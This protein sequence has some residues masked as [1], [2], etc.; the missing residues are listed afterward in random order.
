MYD[1][2]GHIVQIIDS[3]QVGG[4]QKLLVTMAEVLQSHRFRLTIITLDGRPSPIQDRLEALSVPVVHISGH[5]ALF[6]P[7]RLWRIFHFLRRERFDVIHT[8]LTHANILGTV[9]GRLA[10]TPVVASLHNTRLDRRQHSA[11]KE[12]L[13]IAALRYGAC[14]VIAV[15]YVVKEAYRHRLRGKAIDVVA[16]AVSPVS[17]LA[18]IDRAAIRSQLVGDPERPLIIAVGRLTVQKGYPDLLAALDRLRL[19]YPAV[20]LIIAGEGRLKSKLQQQITAM[21]LTDHVLL[22]GQRDD[23]PRLLAAS[24]IYVSASLWE[25]LPVATLEAMAAGLPVVATDVGEVSRMVVAGAGTIVPPQAPAAL[26]EAI[27]P[28]LDSPRKR[29]LLGAMAKAHVSH[30]YDANRWVHQLLTLYSRLHGPVGR[31]WSEERV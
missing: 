29:Q 18:P 16:N 1:K 27:A 14:R 19:T 24:D 30:H 4:A 11:V 20:A 7:K 28:L 31:L 17:A 3:L 8:H 9:A 26:V 15:G 5:K 13:E 2:P 22:L 25:G 23:V 6:N 12:M 10:G 21:G